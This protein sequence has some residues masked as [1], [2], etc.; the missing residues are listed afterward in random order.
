MQRGAATAP[1]SHRG[2]AA[3]AATVRATPATR[4]ACGWVTPVGGRGGERHPA[5]GRNTAA[6]PGGTVRALTT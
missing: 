1:P 5:E 4:P 3:V 2:A 6:R